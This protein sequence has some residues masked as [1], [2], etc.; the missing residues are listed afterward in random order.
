MCIRDRFDTLNER[1]INPY[2]ESYTTHLLT[3]GSNYVTT[4]AIILTG[5]KNDGTAPSD[6]GK[7]YANLNNDLVRDINTTV[8]FDRIASTSSVVDWAV[9]TSYAYGQLIRYNNELYKATDAFTSTTDF[10]DNVGNVY[11]VCLLYTS[12]SPRDLSTSRMPSSA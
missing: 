9:S 6:A 2:E 3:K 12:P 11:K 5:G 10:N 1:S 4:P 7:L 8:K